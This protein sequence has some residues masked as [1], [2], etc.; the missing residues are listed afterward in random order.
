M[1]RLLLV[2][3]NTGSR[4]YTFKTWL[5]GEAFNIVGTTEYVSIRSIYELRGYYSSIVIQ[6][7]KGILEV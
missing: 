6:Y 4:K 1:T 7:D 3:K 2:A 5:R